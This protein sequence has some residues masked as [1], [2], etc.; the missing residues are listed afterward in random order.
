MIRKNKEF[1]IL[2][3]LQKRKKSPRAM[4]YKNEIQREKKLEIYLRTT[5]ESPLLL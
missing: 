3:K 5:T 2:K 4:P 1:L